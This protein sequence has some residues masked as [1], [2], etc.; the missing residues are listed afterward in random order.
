MINGGLH[1]FVGLLFLVI[2]AI[3]TTAWVK[4]FFIVF[5]LARRITRKLWLWFT[6]TNKTAAG[7]EGALDVSSFLLTRIVNKRLVY[8]ILIASMVFNLLIYNYLRYEWHG[9]GN[10]HFK[11]KEYWVAGQVV[12]TYRKVLGRYLHPENPIILP[13]T[14]LQKTIFN[15]GIRYVP[16]KDGEK[17][18]WYSEW[19]LLPY[20]RKY[21][22]PYGVGF[23]ENEPKMV[24]LLDSCWQCMEGLMA[25]KI[26]DEGMHKKFLLG[27]PFLASYYS[28]YQGY[29]T[30]KFHLSAHIIR[31][32]RKYSG[33]NIQVLYWLDRLRQMWANDEYLEEIW[34]RYPFVANCWQDA[35][36]ESVQDLALWLPT[37]GTFSCDHPIML[38]LYRQFQVSMSDDPKKNA[39][40]NLQKNNKRQARLTYESAVYSSQ[41][42]AGR[43]LLTEVCGKKMPAEKVLF[44]NT[45]AHLNIFKEYSYQTERLFKKELGPLLEKEN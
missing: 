19:F 31:T 36:T 25:Q 6:G 30:G 1:I 3:I 16:Q 17:F 4:L 44:H 26:A 13:Y 34:Q 7:E 33:R 20:A 22:R 35:V 18:V 2:C 37:E 29:Y 24:D 10:T 8:K 38:R 39:I 43:Y 42:S 45:A 15:L 12:Y 32:S 5:V 11:A 41:A 21:T 40:L 9:E 27:F 28:T 23:F 14:Y